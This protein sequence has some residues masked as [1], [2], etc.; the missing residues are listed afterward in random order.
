MISIKAR[1]NPYFA[2]PI[3]SPEKSGSFS[4]ASQRL[5]RQRIFGTDGS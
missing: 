1:R 3:F 4:K 2:L 5:L